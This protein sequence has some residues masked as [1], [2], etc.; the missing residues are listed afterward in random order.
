[1][2]TNIY[3]GEDRFF[4]GSPSSVESQLRLVWRKPLLCIPQGDLDTVLWELGRWQ[5]HSVRVEQEG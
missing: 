1:M 4:V 3:T 2:V 5:I